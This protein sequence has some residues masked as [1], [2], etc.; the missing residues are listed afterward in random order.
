MCLLL[1]YLGIPVKTGLPDESDLIFL[2]EL[3]Y[4]SVFLMDET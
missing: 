4:L 1:P 2:S 3:I